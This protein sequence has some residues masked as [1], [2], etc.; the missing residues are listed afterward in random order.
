MPSAKGVLEMDNPRR[1]T[2]ERLIGLVEQVLATPVEDAATYDAT[3]DRP[4]SEIGM[5]SMEMVRL[6]V[7]VE[8]E[9]DVVIPQSDITPANF[10]SLAAV[11]AL[12]SRL[13]VK[14]GAR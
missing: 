11:E 1:G 6:L 2:R 8:V 13:A 12:V 3:Y 10:E 9:F 7:A 4:L 14:P 5:T